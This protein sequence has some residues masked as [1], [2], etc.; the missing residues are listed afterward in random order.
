MARTRP[1]ACSE[2]VHGGHNRDLMDYDSEASGDRNDAGAA[3]DSSSNEDDY[4]RALGQAMRTRCE[5]AKRLR[6]S[7]TKGTARTLSLERT[8]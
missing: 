3:G 5:G 7:R 2:N 6:A 4:T 1:L 8:V